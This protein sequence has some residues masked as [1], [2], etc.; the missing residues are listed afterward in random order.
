[1]SM[2]EIGLLGPLFNRFPRHIVPYQD[3]ILLFCLCIEYSQIYYYN[4]K[5][6]IFRNRALFDPKTL[7]IS[8]D[9]QCLPNDVATRKSG[10][11][12]RLCIYIHYI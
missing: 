12:C 2:L 4:I 7:N 5:W 3:I 11:H 8:Q 10:V 1:M 6:H 9:Y